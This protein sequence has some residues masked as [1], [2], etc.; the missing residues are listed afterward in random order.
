MRILATSAFL[1]ASFSALSQAHADEP[2]FV[3][4]DDSDGY[5]VAFRDD[6]LA[7]DGA[8]LTVPLL[9]VRAG[10]VRTT[11]LRPRTSFLTELRKSVEAL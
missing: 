10:G 11:L 6:L 2:D 9:R 1:I 4:R 5:G 7:G 3:A 8:S